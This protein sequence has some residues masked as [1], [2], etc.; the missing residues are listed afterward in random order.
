MGT[1]GIPEVREVHFGNI[2]FEDDRPVKE[3]EFSPI[4]L[5]DAINNGSVDLVSRLAATKE[6]LYILIATSNFSFSGAELR[7]QTAILADTLGINDT[8]RFEVLLNGTMLSATSFNRYVGVALEKHRN[9][10]TYSRDDKRYIKN[11]VFSVLNSEVFRAAII[12]AKLL[13]ENK[14]G[15]SLPEKYIGEGHSNFRQ[16][17]TIL[18]SLQY[19]G[20][21]SRIEIEKLVSKDSNSF[22]TTS[23]LILDPMLNS[24]L[25]ERED[26]YVFIEKD[27]LNPDLFI[28]NYLLEL[29]ADIENTV[30]TYSEF[31]NYLEKKAF[32]D[33][34]LRAR[35]SDADLRQKLTSAIL[36][37][38]EKARG[39]FVKD[40][41]CNTDNDPGYASATRKYKLTKDGEEYL[42]MIRSFFENPDDSLG[43][44]STY[45]LYDIEEERI[46]TYLRPYSE[47][48]NLLTYVLDRVFR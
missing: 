11:P 27:K 28:D 35:I 16:Q 5:E 19:L 14:F 25:I 29:F 44:A 45:C 15:F 13:L 40:W 47:Y 22:P 37:F 8:N 10:V 41:S 1:P 9:V 17:V 4:S 7:N 23:R 43:P 26:E 48:S 24:K 42:D 46:R 34:K 31:R 12:A 21:M 20:Q 33:V 39:E 36:N 3:F 32:E 30:L 18:N 6:L 38:K 2:E